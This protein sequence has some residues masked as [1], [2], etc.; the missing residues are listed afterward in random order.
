MRKFGLFF[1][2]H[3]NM[4]F[5][6]VFS[7]TTLLALLLFTHNGYASEKMQWQFES[8]DHSW[9]ASS[10]TC[11]LVIESN[12]EAT[13]GSRSCLRFSGTSNKTD[14][15][16]HAVSESRPVS[17]RSLFRLEGWMRVD[18]VE[19]SGQ[20]PALK[21]E[22]IGRDGS[23]V[24]GRAFAESYNGTRENTWQRLSC[25]FRVPADAHYVDLGRGAGRH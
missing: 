20:F 11:S 19:P 17:P 15:W 9:R 3:M 8:Q 5:N 12:N 23:T 24:I 1:K 10:S 18:E 14:D 6:S 25:E 7:L 16:N 13:V 22:F 2:L 4:V 21:C